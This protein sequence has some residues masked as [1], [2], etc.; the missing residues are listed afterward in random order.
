MYKQNKTNSNNVKQIDE[1]DLKQSGSPELRKR[2]PRGAIQLIAEEF[3]NSWMWTYKVINGK[4][5]GDPR[6]ISMALEFA[7]AEDE[8]RNKL[9]MLIESNRRELQKIS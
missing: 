2:L 9:S 8:R 6:I 1:K 4:V 7:R 3:G 5:K